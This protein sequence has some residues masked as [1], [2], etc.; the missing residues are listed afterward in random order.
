MPYRITFKDENGRW[1]LSACGSWQDMPFHPSYPAMSCREFFTRAY[2]EKMAANLEAEMVKK[3]DPIDWAPRSRVQVCEVHPKTQE[4]FLHN[5]KTG[6]CY[7]PYPS[8]L[9]AEKYRA[10]CK[11][12]GPYGEPWAEFVVV[13]ERNLTP[14]MIAWRKARSEM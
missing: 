10:H 8:R 14:E 7:G 3:R 2:A 4:H 12:L 5:D 11:G 1:W 9:F 6:E 13:A